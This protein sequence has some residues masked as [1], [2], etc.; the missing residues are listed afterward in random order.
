MSSGGNKVLIGTDPTFHTYGGH[1]G[2]VLEKNGIAFA[3]AQAG[4][5]GAYVD[6]SCTYSSASPGHA[7]AAAGRA[8]NAWSRIVY[9]GRSAVRR[10][11]LDRDGIGP[12]S[13]AARHRPVELVVLGA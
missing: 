3:G 7:R 11:D 10:L 13:G 8:R 4:A 2:D 9:R 6:L 5:T 1:P 12:D